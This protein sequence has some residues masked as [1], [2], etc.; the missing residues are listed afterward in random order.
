[1]S[2][3]SA[4]APSAAA[5]AA[6]FQR[7]GAPLVSAIEKTSIASMIA[8][9]AAAN[10]Y[11]RRKANIANRVSASAKATRRVIGAISA[12]WPLGS[13]MRRARRSASRSAQTTSTSR[14][15]RACR[16]PRP[17]S[18]PGRLRRRRRRPARAA[19]PQLR[20]GRWRVAPDGVWPTAATRVGWR[21]RHQELASIRPC[22]PHPV[23][24]EGY[25]RNDLCRSGSVQ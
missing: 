9:P 12:S 19:L 16:A 5:A 14:R 25:A 13:A 24:G 21:Q 6:S 1:M 11:Q 18:R 10:A 8:I 4:R 2:A 23:R 3:S 22:S 17:P 15:R 7:K 20:W